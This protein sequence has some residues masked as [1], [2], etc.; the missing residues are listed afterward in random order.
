[1]K[2]SKTNNSDAITMNELFSRWFKFYSSTPS[3]RTREIPS[4]KAI[5]KQNWR[6]GFYLSKTIGPMLAKDI[7]RTHLLLA[8][9]QVTA[10]S[11]EEARKCR[12]I[13]RGMLDYGL[14]R[15]IVEDSVSR[16]ID[17]RRIGLIAARPRDRVLSMDDLEVLWSAIESSSLN[18]VVKCSLKALII[19]GCRRSEV[20]GAKWS[21]FNLETRCWIIPKARMKNRISHEIYIS[22][23]LLE[24]L[25]ELRPLTYNSGYLF[26]SPR[27]ASGPMHPDAINQAFRRMVATT[28]S[29]QLHEMENFT[30]HDLRRSARTAWAQHCKIQP[31]VAEAMLSHLP[32][33]LI[34]TYDRAN[35]WDEKCAGWALWSDLLA[36]SLGLK[37]A[38]SNKTVSVTYLQLVSSK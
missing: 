16:A 33:I 24:I 25:K 22:D 8:L 13:L 18:L 35:Y 23:L 30:I 26:N 2:K 37:H 36:S 27:K 34:Q 3:Y 17:P 11:K 38:D 7:H 29:T 12:S 32:S 10:R 6:W 20:I 5:Y 28:D 19:T 4:D 15:L 9:E 1:M 31:H 21:E 14:D